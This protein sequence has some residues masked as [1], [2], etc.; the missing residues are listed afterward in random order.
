MRKRN[1]FIVFLG[2][3]LILVILGL[4][5]LTSVF[6]YRYIMDQL[7]LPADP[8][9]VAVQGDFEFKKFT[10]EAE[11]KKYLS[12][13]DSN[14][15][16]SGTTDGS[17]SPAV[18]EF[19]TGNS[20]SDKG[21]TVERYS[22][23]NVQV[24]GI[25]EPDILK[26]DGTNVFF[27]SDFW[28]YRYM[29]DMPATNS[30]GVSME[31][32]IAP[33]YYG[34]YGSLNI[35]KV[36]PADQ[37]KSLSKI[38]LTGNLLLNDKTLVVQ[39]STGLYGYNVVDPSKPVKSWTL[40]YGDNFGYVDSRLMNGE[41]YLIT[42]QYLYSYSGCPVVPMK[43]GP[44]DMRI[45]CADI[46]YSPDLSTPNRLYVLYKLDA[47]TGKVKDTVSFVGSGDR[48]VIYMSKDNIYVSYALSGDYVDLIYRFLVENEDLF[49]ST[50]INDV[51]KLKDYDIS[52][53]S[54]MTELSMIM[55]EYMQSLSKDESARIENE[56]TN[57]SEAFIKKNLRTLSYTG[58]VK[59]KN[60]TLDV[61]NTGKVTG[62]LLN[63]F[64]M[65][66]YNGNLRIVTTA[67]DTLFGGFSSGTSETV[68]DLFVLDNG[69]KVTGYVL[70]MGKGERVYSARM[71][72]DRG[73]VV[74]FK[75]VDPFYVLDLS[76]PKNP[77]L[78]GELKIP[79]YSS[80]LHPIK[81][82]MVLGVGI[83]DSKVKLSLFNIADPKNPQEISK[84]S[85][86]EYWTKVSDTHKAFTIDP[87]YEIFFIPGGNGGY[88]F[89]YANNK[90]TLKK[91]VSGY[92]VQRALFINDYLYVVSDT[93]IVVLNEKDWTT[94]KEFK[95]KEDGNIVVPT[96]K[97]IPANLPD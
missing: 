74:T 45:A 46:Y 94:V 48:S 18:P 43:N 47:N 7:D 93:S 57:R 84:Y 77:K 10:D 36:F 64:S 81:E 12:E 80:Y 89:S 50:V 35:L 17:L 44:T 8:G 39:N 41:I 37:M 61:T 73:Y 2:V 20:A 55:N 15:S 56:L 62:T 87:K 97:E 24:N 42:S 53:T 1:V 6:V 71:I 67:G 34:N 11:F 21:S 96:P 72:E 27:S 51:K 19:N 58:L 88:V 5:V 32:T 14:G 65:D 76:D 78:E 85:L 60:D 33:D 66:E 86:D 38:D 49:P 30:N 3:F 40:E 9:D 68:N 52:S 23:T 25:D 28:N 29:Y 91:V 16:G 59:I 79:G 63:Q 92:Q 82:N 4:G 69:L 83:E 13:A 22:G 70:D 26:T 31:K 54:K 95:F 90:L 75:Q